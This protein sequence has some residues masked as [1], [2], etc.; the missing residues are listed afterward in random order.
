MS[1]NESSNSISEGPED[2]P[3]LPEFDAVGVVPTPEPVFEIRENRL[4]DTTESFTSKETK[5]KRHPDTVRKNLAFLILWF[6]LGTYL[7]TIGAFLVS[8]F[9]PTDPELFG[10][11]D[12]TS[13][14]AA[15][16]GLQGLGAAVVGFYFGVKQEESRQ[17][18]ES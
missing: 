10:S 16:S 17:D 7:L 2:G 3:F 5:D 13:A 9:M 6:L 4:P 12:L 15:I 1:T 18:S 8:K 14:I 11:A